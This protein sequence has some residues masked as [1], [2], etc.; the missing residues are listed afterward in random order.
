MYMKQIEEEDDELRTNMEELVE[1]M[2]D[3]NAL[4][5]K[6][7]VGSLLEANEKENL[8]EFLRNNQ[9]VFAWSHKNMP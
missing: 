8:V 1:V 5:R 9:D 6:M 4:E 7:L 3:E 2:L